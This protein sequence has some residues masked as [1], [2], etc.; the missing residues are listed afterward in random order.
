MEDIMKVNKSFEESGWSV[1]GA[2]EAL[3]NDAKE[4]KS[5]FFGMLLVTRGTSLLG[6]LLAGNA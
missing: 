5:G 6:N 3:E 4:Q 2:S 1:K